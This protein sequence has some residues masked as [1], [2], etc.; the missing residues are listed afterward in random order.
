M[1]QPSL[2]PWCYDSAKGAKTSVSSFQL[3]GTVQPHKQVLSSPSHSTVL[4]HFPQQQKLKAQLPHISKQGSHHLIVLLATILMFSWLY[5]EEDNECWDPDSYNH[6]VTYHWV[7][8]NNPKAVRSLGQ[9]LREGHWTALCHQVKVPA[10]PAQ[11]SCI[12]S[13]RQAVWPLF[14]S[15]CHYHLGPL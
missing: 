3:G 10:V 13:P 6:K 5:L 15:C 14:P 7:R 2:F 11:A 9:H 8:N 4:L 1:D 12:V